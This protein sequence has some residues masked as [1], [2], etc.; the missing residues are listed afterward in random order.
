MTVTG[1]GRGVRPLALGSGAASRT[2]AA[3]AFAFT[4]AI[5]VNV[6]WRALASQPFFQRFTHQVAGVHLRAVGRAPLFSMIV[7]QIT[8]LL[9]YAKLDFPYQLAH[10]RPLALC[11]TLIYNMSYTDS[12]SSAWRFRQLIGDDS[13]QERKTA[14]ASRRLCVESLELEIPG[15]FALAVLA[16][17]LPESREP[18]D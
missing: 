7:E 8:R 14:G 13:L 12:L 18:R 10:I 2:W 4:A 17:T 6:Q 5:N 1:Q 16:T 9:R 11:R 15:R 3:C